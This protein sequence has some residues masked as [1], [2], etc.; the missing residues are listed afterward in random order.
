M[1]ADMLELGELSEQ[2]HKEVLDFAL[3]TGLDAVLLYGPQM[4]QAAAAIGSEKLRWFAEKN[5]LAHALKEITAAGD[6]ILIKGSRGMRMEEVIDLLRS[7]KN[8]S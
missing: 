6:I 3:N 1:L 2:A 4:Q 5:E 8:G 7:S